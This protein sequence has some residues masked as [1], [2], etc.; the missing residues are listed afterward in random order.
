VKKTIDV[1]LSV[2][3]LQNAIKELKAYQARLD[4]KCAVIAERLADDGVE[5]ARVQLANL[6][7]IF[8]GELIES[9]QSECVTDTDC[10]HIWAVVAGT[11][12]AAFVE[13][14]TGVIGQKKPYKGELPPGVSWQYASGQ[15]IHQLVFTGT[16]L[17]IGG[18][19][20][21]CHLGHICTILLVNLKEK[22]R[23]L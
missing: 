21:V 15:T 20:R 3:S 9:I 16:T 23:T 19:P 8:K 10:S 14:G 11:D 5:V 13:F 22:S 12:H 18:S 4:H 6:D 17:A 7:A 2:S 1:S